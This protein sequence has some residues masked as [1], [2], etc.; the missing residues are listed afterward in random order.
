MSGSAVFRL[1]PP[2]RWLLRLAVTAG[3]F[4][5]AVVIAWLAVPP[6]FRSQL[7]S[8][9]PEALGRKTTVEAVE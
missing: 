9:L 3:V 6:I 8:R 2:R 7:E 5:A 4:V 1:V